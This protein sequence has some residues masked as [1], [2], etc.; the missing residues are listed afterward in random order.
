MDV[1]FFSIL[2]S[3]TFQLLGKYLNLYKT[4]ISKKNIQNLSNMNLKIS[5]IIPTYNEEKVI[6]RSIE[7][8]QKNKYKNFEIIVIDDNSTDKTFEILKELEIEFKNLRVLRKK[9]IKGKPQSINEAF[10]YITGDI[11]LFLDAD[12]LIDEDFLEE[13]IKYFYNPKTNMIYVDFEAYNY[14]E[15]LIFDYQEIYFEFSRNILYSNLFSKAVFMGNGVF[16]KKNI[17]KKVLPLDTATLVDDVHLAI[18]LNQMKINQIFVI[19]PKTKIQYVSNLK[20][21]FF[22]HKRWYIGGIEEFL[23]ALKY[24]DFN[25]VFINFFLILLL[26]FPIL[27]FLILFKN[28]ALGIF[29]LKNFFSIMWGLNLG[30]ALL[31]TRKMKIPRFLI[32]IFITTP[33]MLFFEYIV[34]LNAY[35]S[36][37]KKEKIW[38]KVKRE[39]I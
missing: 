6:R 26:I 37:N 27:S 5:I 31:L 20:D 33:F 1:L 39:K 36:L 3:M 14:K 23:K 19:S 22:Q 28:L 9:R 38:Y 12:T 10:E 34:L 32:N 2:F 17:L 15:N 29:L 13:H 21:L 11:V 35:L 16:I 7:Y 8:I 24:R 4:F 25:V 18:K 30:S